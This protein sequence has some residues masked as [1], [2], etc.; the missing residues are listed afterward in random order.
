MPVDFTDYLTLP[1]MA[2]L[3]AVVVLVPPAAWTLWRQHKNW[4]AAERIAGEAIYTRT[5]L[6]AAL[7]T[8]PG[9]YF[10]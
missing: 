4:R 3:A 7:E 9:G 10:A 2:G 1:V 5:A 8:A 6:Q